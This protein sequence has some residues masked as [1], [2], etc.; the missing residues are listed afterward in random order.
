MVQPNPLVRSLVLGARRTWVSATS[1]C[2][3]LWGLGQGAA[4]LESVVVVVFHMKKQDNDLV[5]LTGH[6][7]KAVQ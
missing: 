4:T 7:A 3:Q 1:A 6:D 5:F 2:S